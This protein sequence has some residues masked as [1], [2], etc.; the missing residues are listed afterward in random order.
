MTFKDWLEKVY[1]AAVAKGY[2][3]QELNDAQID[4]IDG[5][6]R[7]TSDREVIVKLKTIGG[8]LHVG[9]T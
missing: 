9:I 3:R 2:S 8:K 7:S 6:W 1:L 4:Y 5:S